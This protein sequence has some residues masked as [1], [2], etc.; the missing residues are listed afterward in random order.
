M[1]WSRELRIARRSIRTALKAA[2][3]MGAARIA[4]PIRPPPRLPSGSLAVAPIEV[5]EFG[6]NPGRLRML[7]HLPPS[8]VPHAPL[9]V[10]LHGCGQNP[11]SFAADCG[12]ITLADQLGAPLVLPLQLEDNNQGRCFNWFRPVHTARGSGE[13]SSIRQMVGSAIERFGSDP[14]RVFIAGLSAGGAMAAALLAAY[15]DVFAGGAVAAGLPVGGANNVSEALRRMAEAGLVQPLAAWADLARRAAPNSFR[16]P[17][18][19]LSV[20]HGSADRVVDPENARLLATQ[21]ACLHGVDPAATQIRL[22]GDVRHEQWSSRGKAVVE[23]WR[24]GA[25]GHDW[26]IGAVEHIARFWDI[27]SG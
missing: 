21:W 14:R 13:A 11:V 23:L 7:V 26:P 25:L 22:L 20:W 19:R 15:P 2:S 5:A 1:K 27:A 8:P 12:W 3:A 10:L 9:I 4:A 18:P 17:W 24:L 16:G 6:R